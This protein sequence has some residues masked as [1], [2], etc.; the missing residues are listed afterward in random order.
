M[1][2][3]LDRGD[4][5][6]QPQHWCHV[7]VFYLQHKNLAS[8][9][10]RKNPENPI[11][12]K[13][14]RIRTLSENDGDFYFDES[15]INGLGYEL[16]SVSRFDEAI[17]VLKLNAEKFPQSA[18]AHDSLAEA[19]LKTG[20]NEMAIQHYKTALELEPGLESAS[21]ALKKL[22]AVK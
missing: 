7:R 15:S 5:W 13:L 12:D 10:L 22:G 20:N 9:F 17:E 21:E 1:P 11:G 16:M 19:Y 8:E 14:A 2:I 6:V 4:D 3:Y 18:N